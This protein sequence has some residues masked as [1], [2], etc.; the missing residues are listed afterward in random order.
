MEFIINLLLCIGGIVVYNL[1][2]FRKH[3]KTPKELANKVFWESYIIES[4]FIW[5]W[6]I[7]FSTVV[8]AIVSYSPETAG[9]FKELMGGLDIAYS[10]SG[11]LIFGLAVS[12]LVDTQKK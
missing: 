2:K 3:L 11:A 6:S 8:L 9:A 4:K 10:T 1:F 5:I 7:L 12:S